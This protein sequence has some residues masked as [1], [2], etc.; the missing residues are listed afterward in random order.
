M[1]EEK[2]RGRVF[3]SDELLEKAKFFTENKDYYSATYVLEDVLQKYQKENNQD[4]I[5]KSNTIL[6][7]IYQD[8]RSDDAND[9]MNRFYRPDLA[10][11]SCKKAGIEL[12]Q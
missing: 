1:N 5:K 7:K 3:T 9:I 11:V 2:S 4:G 8:K 10:K 12:N 6:C